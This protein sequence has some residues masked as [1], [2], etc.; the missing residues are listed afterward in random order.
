MNC[1]HVSVGNEQDS[2]MLASTDPR[3]NHIVVYQNAFRYTVYPHPGWLAALIHHEQVHTRQ[4][5]TSRQFYCEFA[6]RVF[7]ITV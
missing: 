1:Q 5:F 6:A 7:Q 4:P 3:T 2:G